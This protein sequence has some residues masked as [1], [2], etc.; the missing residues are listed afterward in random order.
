MSNS[1]MN[2]IN[3]SFGFTGRQVVSNAD[4]DNFLSTTQPKAPNRFLTFL[5]T[6]GTTF[7][8]RFAEAAGIALGIAVGGIALY[9]GC[10]NV[11]ESHDNRRCY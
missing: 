9:A 1:E 10:R 8:T 4:I 7:V 2:I 5:T 11:A 6:H 3:D